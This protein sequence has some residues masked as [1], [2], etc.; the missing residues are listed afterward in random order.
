MAVQRKISRKRN[1]ALKGRELPVLVEGPSQE[2]ELLWEA[3]LAGQAPG[4]DGATYINDDGGHPIAPGQIRLLRV[5]ETHDYDLVG[6]LVDE[7][8][9]TAPPRQPELPPILSEKTTL[10]ISRGL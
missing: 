5:D 3:R 8:P 7:P 2:T 6:A 9:A 1:R 4:I 10:P